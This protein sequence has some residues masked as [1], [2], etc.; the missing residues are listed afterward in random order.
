M[1]GLAEK[2]KQVRKWKVPELKTYLQARGISVSNKKIVE[3]VELTEKANELGLEQTDDHKSP[4]EVVN[5]KLVT[6]DGT[7]TN[8]LNL[9]SD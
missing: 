9:H 3:V 8:P 4:S 6:N 1:A 7:I 5:A 2:D